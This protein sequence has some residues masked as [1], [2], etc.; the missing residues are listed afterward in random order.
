[1]ENKYHDQKVELTLYLPEGTTVY[2]DD[3]TY[4]YHR[5]S[6]YYDDIL[7]NGTEEQYL[8]VIE[9]DMI[10]L[11]CDDDDY[12]VKVNI[13]ND[14]RGIKID[15]DGVDIKTDNSSLKIDEDGVKA[16]SE[17]IKVTIDEDG[18]EIT[19]DDN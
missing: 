7:K 6:D 11:D 5:N 8:K 18:I 1:L 19:S 15:E 4:S 2:A 13:N 10:C 3:N 12:K 16:K 14:S 9:D 17:D